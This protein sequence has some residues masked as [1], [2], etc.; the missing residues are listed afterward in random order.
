LAEEANKV[1][2]GNPFAEDTK[3]GPLVNKVQYD[4]V[5]GYIESAKQAGA[6]IVAGGVR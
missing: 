5:M 1:V 6:S 2:V 3:L 4:K